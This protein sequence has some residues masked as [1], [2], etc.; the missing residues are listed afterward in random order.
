[1]LKIYPKV[2]KLFIA[3]IFLSATIVFGQ[4]DLLKNDLS[5]SFKK[6]DLVQI[7]TQQALT[8]SG[9]GKLLKLRTTERDFELKLE[10]RD[11]RSR[12]YRAEDTGVNGRQKI[13]RG[14]ISTY[15]GFVRGEA[16]SSVRINLSDKKIEGFFVSAGTRF[17]LESAG[18]YSDLAGETDF[19]VYKSVDYLGKDDF[20][21][22]S[23]IVERIQSGK[24]FVTSQGVANLDGPGVIE[25]ATDADFQ[26]VNE[27]GGASQT[28]DEILSILNMVEG[29]YEEQLNLG[30]QVVY[31]HTWST[32]DPYNGANT[33]VLANSFKNHWNTNFPLE[34][35]PRDT[36]HLFSAKSGV[37]S[38]GYAFIGVVCSNP[39]FAYG[40]SGRI[41]WEPGK[42]LVTAHEIAHNINGSHVGASQGCGNSLMNAGLTGATPLVFCEFSRNQI[43]NFVASEQR[44]CL[45]PPANLSTTRFDF[46]GDSKTDAA[47]YRP[48]LGQWWYLQSSDLESRAS[49][50]GT[51]TDIM[52]PA[53]YTGDGKTD[54]AFW[55]EST[56]EL[57]VLRS[58]DSSFY[59]F[60]FGTTGDIPA[61]A[62]FDGDGIDDFAVFRPGTTTWYILK[63]TGGVR[64]EGFGTTGDIPVVSDYDGDGLDDIAVYRPDVHQW[65]INRSSQGVIAFEFGDDG[66][67][68]VPADYTGDGKTDV[69]FWRPAT[70]E[71]FVIRSE[72]TSFYAAPFG[73]ST[74]IPVPGDYD[75][76][77]KADFAVW[78]P[79]D[80]T[81]YLLGS[82]N[83]FSAVG[84][85]SN[86]DI[87][88]PSSFLQ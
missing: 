13:E 61:P 8:D 74:D 10:L 6:F 72:D 40:I 41:S 64:I 79:G 47:I 5:K 73:A 11:L 15:R 27:L 59:S 84:F 78:R 36:A 25:L 23:P 46:D 88:V 12:G 56:G 34:T 17:Y 7:N 85:G 80:T 32:A 54:M 60:P 51:N 31:Q 58:E 43:G 28:N 3:I 33:E 86:G 44:N 57:F 62:D 24:E 65:W 50:F 37:L 1:M 83:G 30:I 53:D 76:D 69:A 18:N 71:W 68:P 38:Q 81:W 20:D 16:D 21:C 63:S 66:D 87:P 14:Q 42:F 55:R 26:F 52:A 82:Q 9:S 29:V 19:V 67:K 39:T 22:H 75:G 45:A 77:G 70:G 2:N 48:S 4:N 35:Y 49:Q